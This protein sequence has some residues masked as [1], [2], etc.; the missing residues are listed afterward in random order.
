MCC[1]FLFFP[2]GFSFTGTDDSQDSRGR[3]GTIF[4]FHSTTST[5]LRTLRHLFATLH[6]KWLSRIFNRNAC[7]YQTAAQWDLPPYRIAIWLIDWWCNV[8]L[9]TWW[10]DSRFLLQR[11]WYGKL[12]N[13]NSHWLST[14]K[15]SLYF[16]KYMSTI[17]KKKLCIVLFD[18]CFWTKKQCCFPYDYFLSAVIYKIILPNII[19]IE[20][21]SLVC[22]YVL[23][24][25]ITSLIPTSQM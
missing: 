6:V 16:S 8:C 2:S 18:C 12:V 5:H 9:S 21:Q 14:P 20:P 11:F 13:L 19:V 1:I 10:I 3:E 15:S 24:W 7:V 23:F 25:N 4:L 17:T 22:L